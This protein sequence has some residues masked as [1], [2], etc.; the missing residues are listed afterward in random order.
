M[1]DSCNDGRAEHW[2]IDQ[3]GQIKHSS[4]GHCLDE[5]QNNQEVELYTCSGATWQKWDIVGKTIVNRHSG[6]CLDIAGCPDGCGART[7]VWAYDCYQPG[8]NQ[9]WEFN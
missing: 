3:Q 9:Q 5:D 2:E 7:N 4:S 8:N 6:R 1:V